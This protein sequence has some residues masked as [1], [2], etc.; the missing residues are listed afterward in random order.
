MR[1]D[2]IGIVVADLDT[3]LQFY[4]ETLGFAQRFR[5]TLDEHGVEVAGLAAGDS[6]VELVR[7]QR[8]DS[9][10]LRFLGPARTKLHHVAFR[11]DDLPA[12]LEDVTSR[13]VTPIDT[14]A[15]RGACASAVAF[16]HPKSTKDVLIE[17]VQR[18]DD[19]E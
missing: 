18:D 1:L 16:L 15:R 7:P 17:L 5:E 6:Y 14:S 12:A 3:T 4:I 10:L 13:G 11:V 2:H 19:P 8:P 9:P